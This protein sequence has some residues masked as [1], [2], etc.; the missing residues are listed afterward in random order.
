MEKYVA[1][2]YQRTNLQLGQARK[3]SFEL[4]FGAG[5]QEMEL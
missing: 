2:D 4:A 5:I 3:G 1:G